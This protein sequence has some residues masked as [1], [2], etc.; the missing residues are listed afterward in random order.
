MDICKSDMLQTCSF[1]NL[2]ANDL[3]VLIQGKLP[4]CFVGFVEE[5]CT[6]PLAG[7]G[8]LHIQVW[9]LPT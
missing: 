8:D 1:A 2:E 6:S 7:H 5:H 9:N 4:N 3:R